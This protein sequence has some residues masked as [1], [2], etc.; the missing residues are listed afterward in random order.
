M[1]ASSTCFNDALARAVIGYYFIYF[2]LIL[3]T[4]LLHSHRRV[5]KDFE[6]ANFAE[7]IAEQKSSQNSM[8]S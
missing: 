2:V 6:R 7:A 5:I 1:T 8:E 3:T 4:M